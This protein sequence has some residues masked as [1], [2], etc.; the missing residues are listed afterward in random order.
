[1][2]PQEENEI[3]GRYLDT[4]ET[5]TLFSAFSVSREMPVDFKT[6]M[7]V[8]EHYQSAGIIEHVGMSHGEVRDI[9]RRLKRCVALEIADEPRDH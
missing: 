2:T 9:Y 5:D 4:L 1:M 8:I 3:V 7:R 6:A